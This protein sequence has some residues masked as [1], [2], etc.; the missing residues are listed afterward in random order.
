MS[1]VEKLKTFNEM[2]GYASLQN[3]LELAILN[4]AK[5]PNFAYKEVLIVCSSLTICDPDDISKTIDKL[6]TQHIQ[7]NAISLSASAYIL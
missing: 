5:V 7:V 4:F 3:S 2:E 6:T 1:K